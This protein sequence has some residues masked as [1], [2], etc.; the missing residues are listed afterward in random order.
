M[1][2]IVQHIR[3]NHVIIIIFSLHR[4]RHAVLILHFKHTLNIAVIRKQVKKCS[5][6]ARVYAYPSDARRGCESWFRRDGCLCR[7]VGG[8]QRLLSANNSRFAHPRPVLHPIVCHESIGYNAAKQIPNW[9]WHE[10]RRGP[11]TWYLDSRQK[12]LLNAGPW[13]LW[14]AGQ[15]QD[16]GLLHS[17]LYISSIN[18]TYVT[19]NGVERRGNAA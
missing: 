14:L 18:Y 12:E 7:M 4:K 3:G 16:K 5:K 8:R 19:G 17:L 11:Q 10:Y 1:P 13:H 9:P 6:K 2:Y 15:G